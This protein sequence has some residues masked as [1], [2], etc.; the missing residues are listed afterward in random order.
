MRSGSL[1]QDIALG[2]SPALEARDLTKHFPVHGGNLLTNARGHYVHAVEAVSLALKPGHVIALVGESGSGKTSVVACWPGSTLPRP[3]RWLYTD[4]RS[5]RREAGSSASTAERCRSSFRTR[6][7]RS[8][9][10]TRSHITWHARSGS[11][12]GSIAGMSRRK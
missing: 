10:C 6:S 3:E 4:A 12:T 1:I 2:D 9:R 7:R 11:I 5:P 8:T